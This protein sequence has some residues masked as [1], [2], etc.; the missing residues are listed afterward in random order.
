MAELH[1]GL[2][3]RTYPIRIEKGLLARLGSDLRSQ[4]IANRY[5]L[6]ADS[7]VAGLYGKEVLDTLRASNI[8]AV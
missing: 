4:A 8:Q 1:V 6:V 2:G 5:A 3:A 7:K